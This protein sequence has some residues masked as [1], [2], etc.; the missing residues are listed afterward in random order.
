MIGAESLM[1]AEGPAAAV[2][3][4]DG[5]GPSLPVDAALVAQAQSNDE[6]AFAQIFQV[7]AQPVTRYVWSILRDTEQ[8]QDVVSQTFLEA[9]R[10]LP[11]LREADRFEA[12]LFRIAYNLSMTEL[13]RPAMQPLEFAA[14]STSPNRDGPEA[15]LERKVI[16]TRVREALTK[17]SDDQR[18]VIVLR[19]YLGLRHRAIAQQMGRSEE[20]VRSLQLRGLR[21]MRKLLTE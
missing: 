18:E 1:A 3:A 13:R 21:R 6:A 16:T 19:I 5:T 14:E 2:E 7:S 15:S 4:A 20:A 17:I 11:H 10:Q 9:W 12:W 8:T